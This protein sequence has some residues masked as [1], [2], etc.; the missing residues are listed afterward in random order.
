MLTNAVFTTSGPVAGTETNGVR[1]F[2]GVPFA[3]AP[4]FARATPLLAWPEP[5]QC[6]DYG[7]YAP[8]PGHL[9]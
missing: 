3:I 6:T 9:D 1:A 8:Q 4:R 2:K 5:R 7:A